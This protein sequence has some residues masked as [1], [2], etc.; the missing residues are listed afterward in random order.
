MISFQKNKYDVINIVFCDFCSTFDVSV[1]FMPG[2]RHP[3]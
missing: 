3:Q 2:G 1:F